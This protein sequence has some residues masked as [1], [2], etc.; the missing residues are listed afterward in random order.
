MRRNQ[1]CFFQLARIDFWQFANRTQHL[2]YQ[3]IRSAQR[4]VD[5]RS[6]TNQPA[7]DCKL[8][9]IV[10]CE[11]R[12]DSAEDRLAF[13]SSLA[14]LCHDSGPDFDLLT[15]SQH[16]CEDGATCDTAF[17]FVDF[18]SRSV[19]VERSD[20]DKSRIGQEIPDGDRNFLDDIFVHG[21]YIVFELRRDGDYWR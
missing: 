14:V 4:R 3:P 5:P 6:D 17:E 19:D 16:T 15:D 11:K 21:L 9:L 20:D 10:F 18:G 8:Q 7:W 2:S 1:T 13:V 12:H